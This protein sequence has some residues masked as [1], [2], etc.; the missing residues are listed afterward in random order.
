[1]V[2]DNLEVNHKAFGKGTVVSYQGKYI[3]V[4][5]D[6]AQ[7]IFVYPEVFEKYLTLADGTIPEEISV[8]IN[9]AKL[10][11]QM[12]IDKKKEENIRAMTKGIVIPGKEG[13]ISEI[14]EEENHY[15]AQEPEEI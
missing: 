4:R 11:K 6:K 1:M 12:I 14:D 8:D 5:F 7:K 9:N 13:A 2:F 3:T 10:K 15:K